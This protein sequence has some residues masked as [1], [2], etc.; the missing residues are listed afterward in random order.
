MHMSLEMGQVVGNLLYGSKLVSDLYVFVVLQGACD[1]PRFSGL[2]N[3]ALI[4]DIPH[5]FWEDYFGV[6]VGLVF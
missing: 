3:K 6:Q 1:Q 4:S 2:D 5:G